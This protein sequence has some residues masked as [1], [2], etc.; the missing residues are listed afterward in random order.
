MTTHPPCGATWTSKAA[1]HCSVCCETFSGTSAGDAH[2]VGSFAEGTRR[3]LD[4]AEMRE[5]GLVLDS[6]GIWVWTVRAFAAPPGRAQSP[7]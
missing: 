4:A 1:E 6:R 2:R 5:A 7:E 3:C